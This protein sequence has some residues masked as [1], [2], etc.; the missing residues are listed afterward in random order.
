MC[1]HMFPPCHPQEAKYLHD[2]IHGNRCIFFIASV[3]TFELL[4]TQ[5]F[6]GTEDTAFGISFTLTD[7]G[8]N[9]TFH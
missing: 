6:A 1:I 8:D 7:T 5:G 9:Y 3:V 2:K 4:R